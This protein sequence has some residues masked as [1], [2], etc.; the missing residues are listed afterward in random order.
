M[1]IV[2]KIVL[3]TLLFFSVSVGAFQQQDYYFRHLTTEDG[4][5]QNT[6]LSILQDDKGFMWFGTKDG[7]NRCDGKSVKVFKYEKDNDYCLG[8]NT[9][10]SLLQLPD[11]K[12]WIGTDKGIYVYDPIYEHFTPFLSKTKKNESIT[13]EVLDMQ[14]DKFGNIWIS[15]QNLFRYS[16]NTNELE[17]FLYTEREFSDES[18]FLAQTWSVNIDYDD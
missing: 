15:S 1:V 5:S 13:N 2:K 6:V 17:T 12:I 14:L 18:S 10:W 16:L 11:G 4:L 3:F 9:I 7:L 8:N